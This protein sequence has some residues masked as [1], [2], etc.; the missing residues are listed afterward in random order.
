MPRKAFISD[1][2]EAIRDFERNNITDLKPGE[3]DGTIS[4]KYHTHDDN[5]TEVTVLVPGKPLPSFGRDRLMYQLTD[6]GEYPDSHMYMMYTDSQ[7]VPQSLH[8]ALDAMS[9]CQGMK[10]IEMMVKV[11][12]TFDKATAG[13]R[14]NPVD[15]EDGDPMVIDSADGESSPSLISNIQRAH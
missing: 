4:F 13:S 5:V 9:D 6:L 1:L 10:V 14:H 7:N 3:E 11:S 12:K 15:L 8:D 2:Q